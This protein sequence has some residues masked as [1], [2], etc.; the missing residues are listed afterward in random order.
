MIHR[1]LLN[2]DMKVVALLATQALKTLFKLEDKNE[3]EKNPI[4]S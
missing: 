3:K 1:F 4:N 2:Y